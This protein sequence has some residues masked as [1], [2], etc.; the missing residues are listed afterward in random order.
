MWQ[1][2]CDPG[3]KWLFLPSKPVLV[4]SL[5]L[6]RFFFWRGFPHGPFHLPSSGHWTSPRYLGA[7]THCGTSCGEYI[8][9]F[10][11]FSNWIPDYIGIRMDVPPHSCWIFAILSYCHGRLW[12]PTQQCALQLFSTSPLSSIHYHIALTTDPSTLFT[13]L[14]SKKSRG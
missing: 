13:T 2:D 6:R 10:S 8:V 14:T 5:R 7:C 9:S 4:G 11:L 12:R 1:R 3:P